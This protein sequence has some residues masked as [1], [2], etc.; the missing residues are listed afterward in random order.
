MMRNYALTLPHCNRRYVTTALQDTTGPHKTPTSYYLTEL[1]QHHALYHLTEQDRAL[2]Y[3]HLTWVNYT[4]TALY[5]TERFHTKPLPFMM[6][7]HPALPIPLQDMTRPYQ[8][9]QNTA[10]TELSRH[11]KSQDISRP[12]RDQTEHNVHYQAKTK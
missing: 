6:L 2:L 12:M 11:Q 7:R 10:N 8:A 5:S 9:P 3:R 1:Y 4:K